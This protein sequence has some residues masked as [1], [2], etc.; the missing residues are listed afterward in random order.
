VFAAAVLATACGNGDDNTAP[1]PTL[2][3][4][5]GAVDVTPSPASIRVAN[6]VPD[7]TAPA[8]DVCL[9]PRGLD[10]FQGPVLAGGN[11]VFVPDGG[12]PND[13]TIE[14]VF[15]NRDD[16]GASGVAFGEMSP[17]ASIPPGPY[18]VRFVVADAPDCSQPIAPD[19]LNAGAFASATLTTVAI[20]GMQTASDPSIAVS[21]MAMVDDAVLTGTS[22]IAL[23]FVNALAQLPW[24]DG[25]TVDAP[26]VDLGTGEAT[27]GAAAATF[28]PIYVGVPY[29]G[30]SDKSQTQIATQSATASVDSHGYGSIAPLLMTG[31]SAHRSGSLFDIAETD[32][33]LMALYIGGG[34]LATA[35]LLPQACTEG[36]SDGGCPL[37]AQIAVYLDNA[38][39]LGSPV[40]PC[41]T[42]A[43]AGTP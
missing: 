42:C 31:L 40:T 24:P 23:R 13:A 37:P 6:W 27:D 7:L 22:K 4:T 2:D 17:Y 16:A 35:V 28:K 9:S 19:L 39:A 10:L 32:P 25:T 14:A 29:G 1:V 20:Y 11:L 5:T 12:P 21:S 43:D 38:P 33:T 18:D 8:I 34:T 36:A 41:V 30:I 3:A 26:T 15:P